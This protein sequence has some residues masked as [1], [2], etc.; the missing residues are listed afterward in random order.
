[1]AGLALAL[2]VP[3]GRTAAA[4]LDTFLK[5]PAHSLSQFLAQVRR[6]EVV[7][8]RYGKHLGI[9]W[10]EVPGHLERR[11]KPG[12]IAKTGYF[13]VYNVTAEGAIFPTKQRLAAG[14][15]IYRLDGSPF[16]F[17][18]RGEP[19]RPFFKPTV[20]QQPPSPPKVGA[21]AG[22]PPSKPDVQVQL[23]SVPS[24]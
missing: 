2:A 1:V 7:Q 3:V 23:V 9:A 8:K 24:E 18:Q 14:T 22:V 5:R 11:L 16:F 12:T 17:T 6:D 10:R 21:N 19:A 4:T 13:T 15:P 20:E